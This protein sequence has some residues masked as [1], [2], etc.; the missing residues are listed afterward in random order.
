MENAD[1]WIFMESLEKL[2]LKFFFNGNRHMKRRQLIWSLVS[3]PT[4][5]VYGDLVN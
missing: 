3:Q 1:T 2:G 5:V 4:C